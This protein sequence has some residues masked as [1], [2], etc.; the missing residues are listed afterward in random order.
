MSELCRDPKDVNKPF[1]LGT[2]IDSDR[3]S[4]TPMS[5]KNIPKLVSPFTS[6]TSENFDKAVVGAV[7][8]KNNSPTPLERVF[9]G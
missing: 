1:R 8:N 9:T 5:V 2:A 7:M 3:C 6:L 4:Y